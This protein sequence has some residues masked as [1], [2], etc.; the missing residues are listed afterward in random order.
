MNEITIESLPAEPYFELENFLNL[1][2]EAKID[3]KTFEKLQKLWDEWTPLLSVRNLK[4]GKNS[5]LAVWLPEEVENKVDKAWE[6]SA[7]KG[8]LTHNL[9][10]FI[11]MSAINDLIPLT[12]EGACAP[13][14]KT[15]PECVGALAKEGLMPPDGAAPI[16]RYSVF[17]YYP[18]KGGCEICA[19]RERC[20][21]G[22]GGG[23]ESASIELP[24]HERRP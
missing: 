11:C 15:T 23:G 13:Y 5:W 4:Q 24:G 21:K 19:L 12:L 20:P 14:P 2:G 10:Q 3:G 16:R 8:W 22:G 9:A 1:S 7:S 18:F 6:E 17:T